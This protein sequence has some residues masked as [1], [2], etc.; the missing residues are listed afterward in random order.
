MAYVPQHICEHIVNL[1]MR[2]STLRLEKRFICMRKC[3]I[4]ESGGLCLPS[5]AHK[6]IL[7]LCKVTQLWRCTQRIDYVKDMP[8]SCCPCNLLA[9]LTQLI[10]LLNMRHSYVAHT[11]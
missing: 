10:Q 2:T 3:L 11:V 6:A 7:V 1:M 5:P 8:A 4:S 9:W